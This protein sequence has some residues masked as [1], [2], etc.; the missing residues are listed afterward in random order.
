[1][2]INRRVGEKD[3]HPPGVTNNKSL[4]T[5]VKDELIDRGMVGSEEVG[6]HRAKGE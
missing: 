2:S 4:K 1:M 3:P 6:Q 5:E